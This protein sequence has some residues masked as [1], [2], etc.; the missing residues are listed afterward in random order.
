[1]KILI[2]FTRSLGN[3]DINYG[4]MFP[5]GL[6]YISSVLKQAGHNVDILNLNHRRGIV[7][8]IIHKTL[9]AGEKYDFVC[10]GGLS[11]YYRQVKEIVDAVH[12]H[13]SDTGIIL[14]GGLISSEP[15]LMFNALN[16]DFIVMGEGEKAIVEL[17]SCIQ[18]NSD[19]SNV[20]GIGY[21][22]KNG[23][24]I[25]NQPQPAIMDLDALPWPDFEGFEFETYLDNLKPTDQY[26]YDLYDFPR[27]YPMVCSRSCPYRCTFCFHPLGNKYRQ[28]SMDSIMQELEFAI[29]RYRLNVIA[30]YDELFSHDKERVYEFCKRFKKLQEEIS[31][32]IKWTCQ[33]RVDGLDEDFLKTMKDAGCYMVSYGFESYNKT[34]LDAMKKH[35]TPEQIDN[36]VK[37]T[38][39]NNISI[40]GNFIFGDRT[41]TVQTANET[42]TYWKNN[43]NAGII[44][45]F[46]S[47]Y[48]G[49]ELYNNCI[50]RGIIKDKLD[51][52]ENHIL[53]VINM[54][55]AITDKEFE[56]LKLD[57]F[58][59]E[60]RYSLYAHPLAL[61]KARNDTYHFLVRCPHC[62]GVIEYKNYQALTS[63][64]IFNI[65]A[66]CRNCRRRFFIT[67]RTYK[68]TT[69]L[70]L[71]TFPL[72]NHRLKSKIYEA[73]S[74][75]VKL[76]PKIKR[77]CKRFF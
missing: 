8:N 50:K 46:I 63:K 68:Y 66:Y 76:K 47:P 15:E 4:Y 58:E 52:I 9:D 29:K 32:E 43:I 40:Q 57:V 48:P 64:L 55:D 77:I 53:D 2:I 16:P 73:K 34:V 13:K 11:P 33:M 6:G 30:I 62:N 37:L 10:T 7:E 69:R 3:D 25:C 14:G 44:L 5:L 61:G 18:N 74:E 12:S 38:L 26:F 67:S 39:K 21:R 70:L 56:K 51:F 59:T 35:I 49:T 65:M 71:L 60:L 41:E 75:L 20:L 19:F 23:K 24:V 27:V 31:W 22:D 72:L 42:L 17:L 28:R 45:G 36:A 1:M 54:T